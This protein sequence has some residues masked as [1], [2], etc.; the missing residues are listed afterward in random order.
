[1]KKKWFYIFTIIISSALI[2]A[3]VVFLFI[4]NYGVKVPDAVAIYT[5]NSK[6][7]IEATLNENSSGYIFKFNDGQNEVTYET[8]NNLVC[9]DNLIEEKIIS[10]GTSY[11]ISVCYKNDYENGYSNFSKETS[12]LASQFLDT[13]YL[14]VMQDYDFE[15]DRLYDVSL[16]WDYV[17][18]ADKYVVYY[19]S[20]EEML[21]YETVNTS[22]DLSFLEGGK[23]NFCVV[24]TS[25]QEKYIDSSKSNSVEATVYHEI[26]PFASAIF[27]KSTKQLTI[28]TFEDVSDVEVWL[29]TNE[30]DGAWHHYPY[31]EGS[32][33]FTKLKINIT[34]QYTIKI[35][36]YVESQTYIAVRP[37][38][39]GFN[40]YKSEP[41]I[42][43]IN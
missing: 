26:Q 22:V 12:W 24:A 16:V 32:T 39:S 27:N 23:H 31:F 19:N 15:N 18:H 6:T 41:I 10:L 29:G 11:N 40:V 30:L 43:I 37:K 13:P 1:M 42:A 21:K 17:D 7:Y 9:A 4:I 5:D 14:M 33:T 28:N 38:A 25:S 34:Y 2:I 36:S 8:K 3:G 35:N 20:G